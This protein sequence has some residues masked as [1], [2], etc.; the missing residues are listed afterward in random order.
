[1]SDE[2]TDLVAKKVWEQL[3]AAALRRLLRDGDSRPYPWD[4]KPLSSPLTAAQKLS[5][6]EQGFGGVG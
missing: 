6:T 1:M 4:Q 5:G 2:F 3:D